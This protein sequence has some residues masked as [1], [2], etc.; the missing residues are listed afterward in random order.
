MPCS[1]SLLAFA[2]LLVGMIITH[3][4]VD[5]SQ[6]IEEYK[7]QLPSSLQS[8]YSRLSGERLRIYYCGY[9]LG[10]VVAGIY[11][12]YSRMTT[13][14]GRKGQI[15]SN[16]WALVATVVVI[17]F[18]VQYYYYILSPKSDYMLNHIQSIEQ[19]RAWLSMY[20]H[21][22]VYCHGGMVLG[23]AAAAMLAFAFRCP[24]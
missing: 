10:L 9:V 23:I 15:F 22:Q 1:L 5:R 11:V 4:A 17:S 12:W 19:N 21:M 6:V 24:A 3:L 13:I 2:A 14:Q 8:L 16:T 18:V 20:R 7:R